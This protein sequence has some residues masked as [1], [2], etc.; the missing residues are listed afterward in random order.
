MYQRLK[1]VYL[2]PILHIKNII[3]NKTYITKQKSM[4]K[5]LLLTMLMAVTWIYGYS[6]QRTEAEAAAIAKAFMQNNGYDFKIT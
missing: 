4:K 1:E 2:R 3:Q 6:Q 5:I